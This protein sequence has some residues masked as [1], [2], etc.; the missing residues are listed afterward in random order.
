MARLARMAWLSAFSVSALIVVACTG[1]SD[2]GGGSGKSGAPDWVAS[3]SLLPGA[4]VNLAGTWYGVVKMIDPPERV[5]SNPLGNS[6]PNLPDQIELPFS[7]TKKNG[8]VVMAPPSYRSPTVKVIGWCS[9]VVAPGHIQVRDEAVASSPNSQ[10]LWVK[11][12]EDITLDGDVIDAV[13]TLKVS[14][15]PTSDS[16]LLVKYRGK[17]HRLTDAES[18]ALIESYKASTESEKQKAGKK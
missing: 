14:G 11:R 15:T 1:H 8:G 7:F 12:E 3:Q 9:R 6:N 4:S 18:K 10:T 13:H 17:L 2:S 5:G 16:Y